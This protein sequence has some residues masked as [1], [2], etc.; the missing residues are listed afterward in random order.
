MSRIRSYRTKLQAAFVTLGLAAIGVTG[1]EA[2]SGASEALRKATFDHLTST[3]ETRCRHIERYFEDLVSHVLALSASESTVAAVEDFR[4]AWNQIPAA[5]ES[6]REKA[7]LLHHY[8]KEFGPRVAREEGGASLVELWFPTDPRA[9]TLQYHFISASPH[10]VGSKDLLVTAP[11]LPGY[12]RPHARHHPTLHRYQTSFG[13]Y[14]IFLIDAA[15]GRILYTVFKEVDLGADLR[16]EPYRRT[17]LARLFERVVASGAAD[18][19]AIEDYAPYAASYFAPAAFLGAPVRRAGITIGV[20]AIQV[21]VDEVNRV[22]TGERQWKAEGLGDSGQAYIVGPDNMLRSDFRFE[23]EAPERHFRELES[24]GV[25]REVIDRIRRYHTAILNLPAGADVAA[26]IKR[27]ERVTEIGTDFRGVQVIRSVAPLKVPGLDWSLVAEIEAEEALAPASALRNRILWIGLL[28]AGAFFAAAR[29]LA[30]SVT[31][32]VRAL[33]QSAS[34][35]GGRDFGVRVPV[36]SNDEIGELAASFNR[37]AE[38]LE[39]T[40]VSKEELEVL[41]R[42]LITAQEEERARLAREL[43]DDLTQRLAAVAIEAGKLERAP[44]QDGE[45]WR[46]GLERIKSQMAG[47]S[48]EVHGLSHRLHPATLQD[49]GLVAAVESEGRGFFERGGPPVSVDTAGDL[50]NLSP[51]ARLCLFRITQEALNNIRR[52]AEASEVS[53]HLERTANDVTLRIQDDGRGF[54][55]TDPAWRPGLGLASMEER[56]RLL[57][58]SLKIESS[59]GQGTTIT[60]R[61]PQG[62]PQ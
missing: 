38:N 22:M 51:D 8:R 46:A 18:E 30:G 33:V 34:R 59:P 24:A 4:V 52:H 56:V 21:S 20:L 32:P 45:R 11:G 14:D 42:R 62:E 53:I 58:G 3:R 10:P 43:H 50:G 1:W 36:N 16:A 48:A 49:L 31:R 57:N 13:F 54:D 41:A 6:G 17:T 37:M 2:S 39:R 44:A 7:S 19:P 27:R 25:G 12:S 60:A 55:R 47:I 28:I 29:F 5:A 35:L 61:L 15:T 26:S 40:T 23:L 9:L